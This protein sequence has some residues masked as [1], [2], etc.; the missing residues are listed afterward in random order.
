[1]KRI[2]NERTEGELIGREDNRNRAD[3]TW[4]ELMRAAKTTTR[5]RK[6]KTRQTQ[7]VKTRRNSESHKTE[8]N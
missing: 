3:E 8:E 2:R 4:A 1:M 5:G 7:E 6:L